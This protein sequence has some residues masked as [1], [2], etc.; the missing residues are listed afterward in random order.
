MR[1]IISATSAA[2]KELFMDEIGFYVVKPKVMCFWESSAGREKS[3]DP[4]ETKR[5]S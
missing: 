5:L 3:A 4:A 2:L 1:A